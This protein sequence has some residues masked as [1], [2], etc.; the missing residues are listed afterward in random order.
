MHFNARMY[1][2][3]QGRFLQ[4]DP[5]IQ[6]PDNAQSWNPYSYCLN[7][8]LTYTDPTGMMSFRQI[9][10]IAIAIVGTVFAPYLANFWWGVVYYAA[11]GAVSGYVST[12]T[13]QGALFGAV[14][15]ALFYGIGSYF[16]GQAFA[17]EFENMMG[18]DI[19]TVGG[20]GLTAGEIGAKILA[21]GIAGGVMSRLQ[22]G[23]F[24]NGFVSAGF[25]EA[26]A[27]G[28]GNIN[29]RVGQGIV[30]SIAGG[31]ASVLTGGKFANGAETAAFSYLFNTGAHTWKNVISRVDGQRQLPSIRELRKNYP[32]FGCSPDHA[33]P[34]ETNDP[35]YQNQCAIRTSVSLM[36]SGFQLTGYEENLTDVGGWARGADGLARYLSDQVGAPIKIPYSEFANDTSSEYYYKKLNGIFYEPRLPIENASPHIDVINNGYTG[37]GI[38]NANEVWYWPAGH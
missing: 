20:T 17:N 34:Y 25:T 4:P 10:G 15:G 24:G 31:T 22:G 11:L 32:C 38:Y 30:A 27:P 35:A 2:P 6:S 12:G 36:D 1:D 29:N 19:A 16:Q 14:S 28:I 21:H 18:G 26:V 23:K 13:M 37:S 33:H 7:N 8:P 9:L 5:V 3:S